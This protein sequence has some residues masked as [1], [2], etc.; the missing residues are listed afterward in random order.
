MQNK[1]NIGDLVR[2][3]IKQMTAYHVP[4]AT[5]MIKLDAMENPFSWSD[6]MKGQWLEVMCAAEPNRYPDPS[7]KALVQELRQCFSVDDELGVVLGNGSDELIQLIIM[8]MKNDAC[9]MAPMPS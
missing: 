6:E 4:E 1:F 7:A 2:P 8:A 5:G 3:E 9:V